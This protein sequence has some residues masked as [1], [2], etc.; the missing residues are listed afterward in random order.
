MSPLI[1][2]QCKQR[3][4]NLPDELRRNPIGRYPAICNPPHHPPTHPREGQQS[5]NW[6]RLARTPI[7]RVRAHFRGL[8]TR[9]AG[10]GFAAPPFAV[11]HASSGRS[12]W[13]FKLS[14]SALRFH[15]HGIHSERAD[16][17]NATNWLLSRGQSGRRRCACQ[18]D[19]SSDLG[20][21]LFNLFWDVAARGNARRRTEYD[22][23]K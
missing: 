11:P 20:G 3:A 23:T 19:T 10:Y 14:L 12:R 15:S 16:G 18:W 7:P 2:R 22:N 8:S 21:L 1:R 4:T 6:N 9:N 17:P 5:P 13:V